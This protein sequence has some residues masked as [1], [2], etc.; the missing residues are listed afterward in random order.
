MLGYTPTNTKKD[1]TYRK[2]DLKAQK[3][4]KVQV[5]KGYYAIPAN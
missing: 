4:E 3:D 2:I 1:G 5:R